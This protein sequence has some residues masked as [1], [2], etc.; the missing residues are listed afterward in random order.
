MEVSSNAKSPDPF[1]STIAKKLNQ[2]ERLALKDLDTRLKALDTLKKHGDPTVGSQ[3]EQIV[4]AANEIFKKQDFH[5]SYGPVSNVLR[6]VGNKIYRVS[7]KEVELIIQKLQVLMQEQVDE[8]IED[9]KKLEEAKELRKKEPFKVSDSITC[10]VKEELGSFIKK[11]AE[12]IQKKEA[13]S[14]KE[15]EGVEKEMVKSEI[16]D[17]DEIHGAFE[18]I[19]QTMIPSPEKAKEMLLKLDT[20]LWKNDPDL[21]AIADE[22]NDRVILNK[23][24]DIIVDKL[25]GEED[26]YKLSRKLVEGALSSSYF[27]SKGKIIKYI[28]AKDSKGLKV[29]EAAKQLTFLGKGGQK[30]ARVFP[31]LSDASDIQETTVI[32]TMRKEQVRNEGQRAMAVAVTKK[33]QG[34]EHVLTGR[35]TLY[36]N[37]AGE[38]QTIFYSPR[39]E[40]DMSK[41]LKPEDPQ[42]EGPQI[43]QVITFVQQI[44]M[45]VQ[46][47]HAKGVVHLDL[48]EA[49]ILIVDGK[50]YVADFDCARDK[51]FKL[52]PGGTEGYWS[53][54]IE[55]LYE[56]KIL[57][58][59]PGEAYSVDEAKKSDIY[60]LGVIFG[61]SLGLTQVKK[62]K[63]AFPSNNNNNFTDEAKDKITIFINRMLHDKLEK[64]PSIEEVVEFT[65]QLKIW[66][67][68]A[69][70]AQSS[71]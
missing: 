63:Y 62:G 18:T 43:D 49:N 58:V 34:V 46:G 32:S 22:V 9:A 64:R 60:S 31:T 65:D 15:E 6:N 40:S 19:K 61:N 12:G 14:I 27:I 67:E 48:K 23:V 50:A 5:R 55:G 2:T 20:T 42:S 30:V 38:E 70:K 13:P 21:K 7:S 16:K 52:F 36:R 47:I 8:R 68:E 53:P 59:P 45:G 33:L 11:D 37:P 66:R 51:E 4:N 39:A 41:Y 10:A 17:V 71:T 44:A 26:Y 35:P 69:K 57:K 29:A 54:E 3:R 24:R 28:H 56:A 25:P 1:L